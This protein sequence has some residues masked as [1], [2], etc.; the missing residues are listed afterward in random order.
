MAMDQ[1]QKELQELKREYATKV[2]KLKETE[3]ELSTLINVHKS[4]VEEVGPK[5]E[6]L[7]QLLPRKIPFLD[8]GNFIFNVAFR[9]SLIL[10]QAKCLYLL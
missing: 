3:V 8:E 6:I 4:Y 1:L 7:M 2:V 9:F 10:V 5:L